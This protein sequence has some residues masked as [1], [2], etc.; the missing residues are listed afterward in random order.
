MEYFQYDV[1]RKIACFVAT[2]E[3]TRDDST[4]I[5]HETGLE[6]SAPPTH[7]PW[8]N[9]MRVFKLCLLVSEREG[10]AIPTP[11]AL[12]LAQPGAVTCDEYMHFL[13]Q[14]TTDPS[15][16]LSGWD[17]LPTTGFVRHPLCFSLKYLLAKSA[18]LN[19]SVT[20]INEIIGA[21]IHSNFT[22][23][24]DATAFLNLMLTSAHYE[25]IATS[26]NP[27]Q[28]RESIKF[29]AQISYLHNVGQNII[30]SLNQ[31]DAREIFEAIC[32]ISGHRDTDGNDEIQRLATL[33]KD[34]SE[35]DFFNYG[36]SV[37]SDVIES[38]FVEGNKVEK[39]HVV[40]ERNLRL[41]NM[42]FEKNPTS[43]CDACFQDTQK[44]YPWVKRL[45][46][47]HH[48][49]PLSSG[50]RVDSKRGTLLED[51]VPICP[52]CHRAVHRFYDKYLKRIGRPDFTNEQ[53]AQTVYGD[54]KSSIIKENYYARH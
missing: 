46:D 30:V 47:I 9:Y 50:T 40:I 8:R 6:F 24:E 39:T 44:K 16:A 4:L 51:L 48:I 28:A 15:P 37:I 7:P 32:P 54:A 22:G 11:V 19:N 12:I 26:H 25:E 17:N 18:C 27:R 41:R 45:L 13:V 35:Y 42:F 10:R 1:L 34:G 52:T 20:S 3:W 43:V 23:G 36:S 31:E 14:A 33:F 2:H 5:R 38:G 53:E 49:L 21:Y 29:L